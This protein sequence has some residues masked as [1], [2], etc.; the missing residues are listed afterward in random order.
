L[1][2]RLRDSAIPLEVCPTSNVRTGVVSSFARHPLPRLLAEG[3]VVSLN[4]DDPAMFHTHLDDE[5]LNVARAF[6]LGPS[7]LADVARSGVRSAFLAPGDAE[8]LLAE[9]DSVPCPNEVVSSAPS[10]TSLA[11]ESSLL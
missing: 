5:Y 8:A 1:I 4:T 2:A 3:L 10:R 7:A 11:F 6:G 9:I